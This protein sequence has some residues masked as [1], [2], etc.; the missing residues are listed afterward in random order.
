LRKIA[1]GRGDEKTIA[2]LAGERTRLAREQADAVALKNA[3]AR[4]ELVEAGAVER[5]W[6]DVLRGVRAAMLTMPSRVQR[7]LPTLTPTE[8][9]TIDAEVRDLL[10]EVGNSGGAA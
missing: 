7:R 1:S 9:A 4:G 5:E 8:V 3:V 6:S 2:S 10:C